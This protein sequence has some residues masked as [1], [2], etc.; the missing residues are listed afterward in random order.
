MIED[1]F[2]AVGLLAARG[3]AADAA[4]VRPG[5]GGGL[6]GPAPGWPARA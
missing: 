6:G 5:A 1:A 3:E 4:A 2:A